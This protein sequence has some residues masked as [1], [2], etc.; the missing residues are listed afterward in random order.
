MEQRLATALGSDLR[1]MDLLNKLRT[2]KL[3]RKILKNL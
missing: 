1:I 2:R 3:Q